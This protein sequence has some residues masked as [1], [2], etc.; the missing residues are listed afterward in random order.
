MALD[1]KLLNSLP[2]TLVDMYGLVEIDI[3]SDMAR[4]ISTYDYFIPAAQHQ[5]QK[6]QELGMVQSEI[7][8]R[9][10]ALTG[11]TQAEIVS[12]LSEASAEAVADD[13]EYYTAAEVYEP[14]KVNTEA[15]HAQLNSGL[16]QTQ[17]SFFN[18]TRT[19][20]NTASKQFE[21]ALDRAW[22]QINSGGFDYNTAI[23]NAVTDLARDG[24]G[25]IE[26]KSGRIDNIEVAVRRAVVTGANQ[27]AMRTQEVLSDELEVD[28]VEVTAHG[29][30]RPSHA[31]WQGQVFSRKGRVTIDGVTYED[32]TKATGY[33]RADGLGGVNCRHNFH[34]YVPG[35]PRSWSDK[36]LEALEEK[37]VEYNGEKLTEYEA[38]QVQ[39]KIEREIRAAKRTVAAI[40]ATGGDASAER[41]MLRDAQKSYTD[42][43][44]KTGMRKQSARTQIPKVETPPQTNP[45][46]KTTEADFYKARSNRLD[47]EKKLLEAQGEYRMGNYKEKVL[48][49]YADLDGVTQGDVEKLRQEVSTLQTEREE[50]AAK[51]ARNRAR[52]ERGTPE[53][54]EW[55]AW[56]AKEWDNSLRERQFAV[57]E[58][59]A[60]KNGEISRYNA[61]FD[62]VKAAESLPT[63][64]DLTD[65]IASLEQSVADNTEAMKRKAVELT[66]PE[67]LVGAKKAKPMSYEKAGGNNANP[68]YEQGG[69]YQ[70]NC[71]SCVVAYEARRRGYNVEALPKG[72]V[73]ERVSRQTNLA[74]IDPETGDHPKYISDP[75]IKTHTEMYDFVK[76]VVEDGKRYTLGFDWK[77]RDSGHIIHVSKES[78]GE[79][80]LFDPQVGREIRG[81]SIW[82][83]MNRFDYESN[84]SPQLLRVDNMG[85]DAEIAS[86]ILKAVEE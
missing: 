27:T 4:R 21:R 13:V 71:Q 34:P 5:M 14:S 41:K 40:E 79:L 15:L 49:K 1:P 56:R 44:E 57:A 70:I 76:S 22:T 77:G 33:G 24:I 62:A 26:Y 16:L 68:N 36:E 63:K 59:I 48:D 28:L 78:N 80:V 58:Q 23:K 51:V 12:L 3:L 46:P 11:Q 9:L 31:K 6:L 83:Y 25:S 84:K 61:Y 67:E 18:I 75:T 10:S 38:S 65:R 43:S 74:W 55:K 30:A 39:R 17:N 60:Q 20:A 53:Y 42:F 35:A 86:G 32:L 81:A 85:F 82:G 29:G 52:P 37:K 72:A 69:G 73:G 64:Q 47:A 19:T 8:A 2:D 66:L 7:I 50:I 54:D 45:K